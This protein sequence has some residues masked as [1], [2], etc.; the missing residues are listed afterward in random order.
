MSLPSARGRSGCTFAAKFDAR[1]LIRV[2]RLKVLLLFGR[3]I[4]DVN[5]CFRR[6]YPA[7]EIFRIRTRRRNAGVLELMRGVLW[8]ATI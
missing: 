1:D 6:Y 7:K 3:E 4:G 8:V 2:S 5:D